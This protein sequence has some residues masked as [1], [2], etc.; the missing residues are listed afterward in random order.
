MPPQ[1]SLWATL[2]P[3]SAGVLNRFASAFART[4]E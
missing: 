2:L 1:A 3:G 4:L